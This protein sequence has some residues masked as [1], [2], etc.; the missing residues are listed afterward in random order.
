MSD[1]PIFDNMDS[2]TP[3]FDELVK[4]EEE[5]TPP[6][7]D[8]WWQHF[9]NPTFRRW[10]YGVTAAAVTA[11]AIWA[12]KPEFAVTA[13]PLIMAIFYVDKSGTPNA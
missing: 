7:P 11:G 6:K 8:A 1:T 10:A 2:D 3:I 5:E 13:A 12:G 9:L 4:P